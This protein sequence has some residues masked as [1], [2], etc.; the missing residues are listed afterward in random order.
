M[1]TPLSKAEIGAIGEEIA[2][3]F[4]RKQKYQILGRNLRFKHSEVDIL[5]HDPEDDVLVFVE[6]KTR[7]R[8][9]EDFLPEKNAGRKKW[10]ALHRA[11]RSYV[12]HNGYEGGYRIDL[13]SVVEGA[14]LFHVKE[15]GCR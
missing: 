6:V 10:A 15:V 11:M 5:A 8:Y 4:L 2:S 12:A 3:V 1:N 13:I 9:C 14:V 7:S